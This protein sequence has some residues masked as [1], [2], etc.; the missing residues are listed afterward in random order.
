MQEINLQECICASDNQSSPVKL[1]GASA[2]LAVYP[3]YEVNL[4]P[5]TEIQLG[6][7]KSLYLNSALKNSEA[8][9]WE[10]NVLSAFSSMPFPEK[11]DDAMKWEWL[12]GQPDNKIY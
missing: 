6:S 4:Q 7:Q 10:G 5:P 3:C 9:C 2:G 1:L 11:A 8:Y 12:S